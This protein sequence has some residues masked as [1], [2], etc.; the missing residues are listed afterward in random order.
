MVGAVTNKYVFSQCMADKYRRCSQF[1]VQ[2]HKHV[3]DWWIDFVNV[4]FYPP[5]PERPKNQS[6]LTFLP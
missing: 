3:I 5:S 1:Y 6:E 4:C 2:T